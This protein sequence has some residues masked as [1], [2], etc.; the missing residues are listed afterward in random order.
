MKN[1]HLKFALLSVEYLKWQFVTIMFALCTLSSSAGWMVGTFISRLG[2]FAL[3]FSNS[4]FCHLT[5]ATIHLQSPT[6]DSS[7]GKYTT[8]S[9]LAKM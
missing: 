2:L 7:R 9:H 1:K 6:E 3:S 4:L 5:L 8:C